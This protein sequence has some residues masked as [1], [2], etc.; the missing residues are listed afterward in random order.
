MPSFTLRPARESES[1]QIRELIHLVGIN[2]TGLDWRRFIVAANERDEM[3]GCG[4]LKPHGA[5]ILELA[6]LAVYPE[7]RGKGVARAIVEYLLANSPRP[8]YLMCASPLGP[9][10][11][12]FGF[13]SLRYEEMP[14]Y[15]QRIARL[16]GLLTSL[17]RRGERLL[18]MKLQ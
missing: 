5:D 1:R 11:E 3:I 7:H 2:P 13:R 15:F 16:A 18:V 12:K 14:P 8:L 6:S 9:F 4:Q 17:A 10:Y